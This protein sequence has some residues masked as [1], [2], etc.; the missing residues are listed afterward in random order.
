MSTPTNPTNYILSS[1]IEYPHT[2]SI[3]VL[4]YS[5]DGSIL[6]SGSSDGTVKLFKH[7]SNN[8][9]ITYNDYV[10]LDNLHDLGINDI[11]IDDSTQYIATAPDDKHIGIWSIETA[12]PLRLLKGH[13]NSVMCVS[14]NSSGSL[15][16]SGGFDEC[17]RLWDLRMYIIS[18]NTMCNN[19]LYSCI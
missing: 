1:V 16:V 15:L 18:Y 11:S 19:V 10:T 14:F 9:T 5:R 6:G 17:I 8:N 13:T 12:Q 2:R 3:S 4:K 7:N